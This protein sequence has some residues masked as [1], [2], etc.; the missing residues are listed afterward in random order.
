MR[1]IGGDVVLGDR[2]WTVDATLQR[3]KY[4]GLYLEPH[5]LMD[6]HIGRELRFGKRHRNRDF[7]LEIFRKGVAQEIPLRVLHSYCCQFS[8][9]YEIEVFSL[10][11]KNLPEPFMGP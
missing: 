10:A 11:M 3:C 8:F 4:M 7:D 5:F 1:A 2:R 9:S 6:G